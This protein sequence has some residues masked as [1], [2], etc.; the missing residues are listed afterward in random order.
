MKQ[1]VFALTKQ[2]SG[3]KKTA[4]STRR[5]LADQPPQQGI[6]QVQAQASKQGLVRN[7]GLCGLKS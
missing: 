7:A 3:R 2:A 5:P 1:G 4:D 6:F